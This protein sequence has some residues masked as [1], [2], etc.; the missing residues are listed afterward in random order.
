MIIFIDFIIQKTP[1]NHPFGT[2]PT[3]TSG[4]KIQH[5]VVLA[6]GDIILIMATGEKGQNLGVAMSIAVKTNT[7]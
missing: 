2:H 6:T 3:T 7:D 5:I 4:G 1:T